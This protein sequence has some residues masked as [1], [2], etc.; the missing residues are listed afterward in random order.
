M[1]QLDGEK[2]R[3]HLSRF[4]PAAE[5]IR[6]EAGGRNGDVSTLNASTASNQA[7]E[8]DDVFVYVSPPPAPFPRVFPGL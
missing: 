2:H 3:N 5:E 4:N 8:C 6:S 7:S 1:I